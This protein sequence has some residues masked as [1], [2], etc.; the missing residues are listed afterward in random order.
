MAIYLEKPFKRKSITALAQV[1]YGYTLAD[2][3][4]NMFFSLENMFVLVC[5]ANKT[6]TQNA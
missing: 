4:A 5:A 2:Y 6:H 3:F 1:F